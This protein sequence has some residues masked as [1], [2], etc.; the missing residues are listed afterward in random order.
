M[1]EMRLMGIVQRGRNRLFIFTGATNIC[2]PVSSAG[3][4]LDGFEG[5]L[6]AQRKQR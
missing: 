5:S 3:D 4:W 1:E 2:A 6:V